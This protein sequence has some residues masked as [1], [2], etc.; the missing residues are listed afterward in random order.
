MLYTNRLHTGIILNVLICTASAR[1]I[2]L[3]NTLFADR[4]GN[5]TMNIFR[6]C[7]EFSQLGLT[8]A[9]NDVQHLTNHETQNWAPASNRSTQANIHNKN[10]AGFHLKISWKETETDRGETN[11]DQEETQ[12]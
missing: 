3:L 8:L 12:D 11:K 4:I 7:A 9:G 6:V 5:V 2:T 10:P 1:P